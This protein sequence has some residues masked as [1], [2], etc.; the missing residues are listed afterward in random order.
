[1]V[2][3]GIQFLLEQMYSITDE[4]KATWLEGLLFQSYIIC[5][6]LCLCL[7]FIYHWFG[8]IS[9]D[10]HRDLL[11]LD[12]TGVALLVAGSFFPGIYYGF[13][14]SPVLQMRYLILSLGVLIVG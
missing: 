7:S 2:V 1:M 13:I 3:V 4:L 10:A 14:C 5:A 11:R 8:C 6:A 12:L 9:E